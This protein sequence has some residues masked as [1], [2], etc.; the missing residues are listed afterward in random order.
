MSEPPLFAPD[1]TLKPL[2]PQEGDDE[3]L[4][5]L[6]VDVLHK[7][8][9]KLDLGDTRVADVGLRALA[10]DW[11]HLRVISL[12]NCANITDAG[13]TAIAKHC[14]LDV[15]DLSDTRSFKSR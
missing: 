10:R 14:S 8:L 5:W 6:A 12:S 13:V 1:P 7:G 11:T 3:L 9:D 4:A 15:I 2:S